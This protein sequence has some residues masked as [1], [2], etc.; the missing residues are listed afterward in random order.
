MKNLKIIAAIFLSLLLIATTTV[1][2]SQCDNPG[3]NPPTPPSPPPPTPP[4]PP[5]PP[6]SH[7]NPPSNPGPSPGP[8]IP[9][10][11]KI[12]LKFSEDNPEQIT[13]DGSVNLS[14]TGGTG[15]YTWSVTGAGFS[16]G[17]TT[18]AGSQAV[19]GWE[20]TT[21]SKNTLLAGLCPDKSATVVV[22]DST[23]QTASISVE[24]LYDWRLINTFTIEPN[25]PKPPGFSVAA[26]VRKDDG[27]GYW[28]L[29]AEGDKYKVAEYYSD[30]QYASMGCKAFGGMGY[31]ECKSLC[32]TNPI[33]CDFWI[34]GGS[35][36]TYTGQPTGDFKYPC[37]NQ[38]CVYL[39]ER[40]VYCRGH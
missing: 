11:I 18:T 39:A 20:V 9:I 3:P 32:D 13:P 29:E 17:S 21:N 34:L 26:A 10:D 30:E 14:V 15:P 31:I 22:S 2:A 6:N 8:S 24:C 7:P 23:G 35:C 27:G 19:Q 33:F 16:L 28:H 38:T 4:P 40:N 1:S 36:A 25:F 5:S 37:C 12:P